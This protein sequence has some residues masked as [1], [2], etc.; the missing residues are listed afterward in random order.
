MGEAIL[1]SL[2]SAV[3]EAERDENA[4][5]CFRINIF[6]KHDQPWIHYSGCVH[7][8]GPHPSSSG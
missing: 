1:S 2:G 3:E 7:I 5:K 8:Q 4:L 6:Q